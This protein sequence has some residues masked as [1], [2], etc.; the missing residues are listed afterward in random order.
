[1][2]RASSGRYPYRRK[3]FENLFSVGNHDCSEYNS[4]HSYQRYQEIFLK[5]EFVYNQTENRYRVF[6]LHYAALIFSLAKHPE[7]I[8]LSRLSHLCMYVF[9]PTYKLK[10]RSRPFYL[11]LPKLI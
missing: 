5:K 11:I 7:K 10:T 3:K 6:D 8:F 4:Y 9:L 1:M 2:D